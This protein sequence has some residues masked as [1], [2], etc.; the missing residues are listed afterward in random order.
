MP[1]II[2]KKFINS[3]PIFLI[4]SLLGLS[5]SALVFNFNIEIDRIGDKLG[6]SISVPEVEA[7]SYDVATT[8]VTV[9]NAA[10]VFTVNP[11]EDPSSA[12]TTPV[13]VGSTIDFVATASDAEGNDYYLLVC[14]QDGATPGEDGAAPSCT[15]TQLC[16]SGVTTEQTQ[17]SCTHTVASLAPETQ[18]WVAYVCDNHSTEAACVENS[19]SGSG[20]SGSPFYRNHAPVLASVSTTVNNQEPGEDFSF[21]ALVTDSDV[22]GG[23]DVLEL[24]ICS[25][26]VWNSSGGCDAD[27]LCTATSTSPN[28]SCTWTSTIPLNDTSYSY[29]AFVKDWHEMVASGNSK[30]STYTVA[31]AAP[32]ISSILINNGSPITLN[33]KGAPNVTVYASSTT[34]TDNNGCQDIV[35]ATATIYWSDAT[36]GAN[37]TADDNDCYKIASGACTIDASTCTGPDDVDVAIQCSAN[38]AYHAVPT[39]IGDSNPHGGTSWIASIRAFDEALSYATSSP[40]VNLNVSTAIE[41]NEVEI[42]YGSLIAGTDTGADNATTTIVNAGNSPLDTLLLG[43]DMLKDGLGPEYIPASNQEFSL[44]NFTYGSGGIAIASSSDTLADITAPRPTGTTV[45]DSIYWGIGVP[46]ILSGDYTGLNTFT[47]ALD[48][49]VAG[50][51]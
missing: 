27:T 20:D 30:T 35:S 33:I 48:V 43:D 32:S 31:N 42:T 50:E 2:K 16:V 21:E 37:C 39:V 9:K 28:V 8:T 12:S 13:N 45:A 6:L 15:N 41:V 44:S 46:I 4:L 34:I 51:W 24:H 38:L 25:T 18:S 40:G 49:D 10:P 22:E 23:A 1:K 36:G 14:N 11:A 7:Q 5:V 3:L 29:Y 19:H 17:A 26:N 47:A